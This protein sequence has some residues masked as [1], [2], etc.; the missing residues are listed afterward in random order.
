MDPLEQTPVETYESLASLMELTL[1]APNLTADDIDEGCRA[2]REYGL[3]AVVVRPC[4]VQM[5]SRWMAVVQSKSQAWPV[6]LTGSLP[7]ARSFT[8][9]RPDSSRGA[10]ARLCA[11]PGGNDVA[12]VRARRNGINADGPLSS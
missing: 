3:A 9:A 12:A 11:K 5:A 8:R 6:T 4:D 7:L 10:R 2:A 1:L